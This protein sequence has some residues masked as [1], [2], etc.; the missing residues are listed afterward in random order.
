MMAFL[1]CKAKEPKPLPAS[2]A[3]ASSSHESVLNLRSKNMEQGF[4]HYK[5]EE[6][7][8]KMDNPDFAPLLTQIMQDPKSEILIDAPP[9]GDFD[10]CNELPVYGVRQEEMQTNYY[11]RLQRLGIIVAVVAE[12]NR[13]FAEEA[14]FRKE[15]DQPI[16]PKD[17]SSFRPGS[18][19][20]ESFVIKTRERIPSLPWTP[21]TY[22]CR[23]LVFNKMSN[24]IQFQLV[25]GQKEAKKPQHEESQVPE[26]PIGALTFDNPFGQVKLPSQQ[27]ILLS[28]GSSAMTSDLLKSK[29]QISYNVPVSDEL[30]TYPISGKQDKKEVRISLLFAGAENAGPYLLSIPIP[31]NELTN[32]GEGAVFLQGNVSIDF[33][34]I[35]GFK[36][37]PQKYAIYGVYGAVISDPLVV[38]VK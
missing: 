2:G 34:K 5:P 1:S 23:L 18:F 7:W 37:T 24:C 28:A 21:G 17:S 31:V 19:S 9:F 29:L 10:K 14:F 35:P 16:V 27:G 36:L 33:S 12:G 6:Y 20:S 26:T 25:N 3:A 22:Y 4:L 30:A 13:V 38:Q 11:Y 8:S 32:S 15:P